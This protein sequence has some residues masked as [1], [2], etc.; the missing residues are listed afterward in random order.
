MAAVRAGWLC[1]LWLLRCCPAVSAVELLLLSGF[2]GCGCCKAVPAVTA[3]RLW[4]LRGRLLSGFVGCCCCVAVPAVACFAVLAAAQLCR[5]SLL[6]GFV[7]Y[8]CC[9]TVPGLV[10]GCSVAM[11]TVAAAYRTFSLLSTTHTQETY[12]NIIIS[13]L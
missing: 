2:V 10:C 3:F 13:F 7:G 12:T 9:E 8:G 4:L 5:L 1:Q 6:S 11:L